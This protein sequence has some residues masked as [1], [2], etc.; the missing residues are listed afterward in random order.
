MVLKN[1]FFSFLK[2][3]PFLF[4][5][6]LILVAF[7]QPA[8]I[9]AFCYFVSIGGFLIF[10]KSIEKLSSY[11]KFWT[12]FVWFFI[13]Q[14][15]QLSWMTSVKYQGP[16]I[17]LV[18]LFILFM[19]A[20]AFS[21]LALYILKKNISLMQI[22]LICSCWTLFE[23]S[24]LFFLCG[25]SWNPIGMT[26]VHNNFSLQLASI[27][28]MFGLTFW[29][30]FT[31]LIGYKYLQERSK[32]MMFSWVILAVFPY[33]FGIVNEK[34]QEK[35]FQKAGTLSTI[36]VQTA[37]L[38]E[39]KGLMKGYY[40]DFIS[41]LVQWERIFSFIEE[42]KKD[43]IDIIV[44]PEAALPYG[45]YYAFYPFELTVDL[46]ENFYGRKSLLSLPELKEPLAKKREDG[47]YLSNAFF[48]QG[49]A[50]YYN[51]KVIVGLDDYDAQ[52]KKSYNAAFYFQPNE[53]ALRYEKRK[54]VP[55]AEYF[56]F[57][58]CADI[59]AKK[60]G[61]LGTFT[62]GSE[63]KVFGRECPLSIS[64]CYEET[65]P[66]LIREG[67][68]K[69][70]K[71]FVNITND[72]WFPNSKLFKQHYY[73]GFIRAVENGVPL[74]RSCNTGITAGV[75]CFGRI[76]NEITKENHAGAINVSI[77]LY[78]YFTLYS[79]WGDY[80]IIGFSILIILVSSINKLSFFLLKRNRF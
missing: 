41:P 80:L 5:S 10:W 33:L 56:P 66:H 29:V 18:Y 57:N 67:K 64:V 36:L 25:F 17:L 65:Y 28:G 38:P 8:W 13:V 76:I 48:A 58:F 47:W 55:I 31:N 39:Q 19:M 63:A 35:N 12:A 32:V 2:S 51:A 70:A 75:D 60:Y 42:E 52:L 22:L 53:E 21:F 44:L 34:V 4:L 72:G 59:A 6:S 71:L 73:H 49:L 30:L 37:L 45:A 77:P 26:L 74:L 78:N 15:I 40:D 24:R 68:L 11:K 1:S 50:N 79:F 62:H 23:W 46:W 43:K 69:G 54:L 9:G 16:Y 7:G 3:S 14:S 27:F 61:I 20:V